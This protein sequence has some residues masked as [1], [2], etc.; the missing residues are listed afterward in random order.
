MS[1][2]LIDKFYTYRYLQKKKG[3]ILYNDSI[4]EHKRRVLYFGIY[5]NHHN[6]DRKNS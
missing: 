1:L 5:Q 4:K 6:I 3:M 2:V